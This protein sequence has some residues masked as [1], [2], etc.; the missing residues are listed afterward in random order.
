MNRK[1]ARM[2]ARMYPRA[3]RERYGAEFAALLEDRPGGPGTA[4]NVMVSALVERAFPTVGGTMAETSRWEKWSRRAPWAL[5]GV[6][7]VAVLAGA[8]TAALLI[9]WSGWRMFLPDEQT[10][11]VPIHGWAVAWFGVGRML[12]YGAPVIAG[13]WLAVTAAR[14]RTS[15]TWPLI[16]AAAIAVIDGAVQVVT[17]RPSLS[18]AGRVGLEVMDWRPGYSAVVLGCTIAVYLFMKMQTRSRTE[19]S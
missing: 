15:V 10:P 8:Y 6:V 5:F 11:F 17:V 1:L 14:S 7:P 9:L 3:W 2:L 16:G 19:A 13:L 4:L 12:Y 18:A